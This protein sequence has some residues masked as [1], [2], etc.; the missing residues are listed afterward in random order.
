GKAVLD[1]ARAA[2]RLSGTGL[3]NA[4]PVGVMGYSQG[5]TSAGWAAQLAP[6]YAPD[7]KLKGVVAGG[8]PADLSAVANFLDG[9]LAFAFALM[10]AV[11]YDAAY[12]GLNLDGYLNA[13]GKALLANMQ[14]ICLVSVDGISGLVTTAFHHVS[15]YTTTNPLNTPQW[16]A[17]LNENKL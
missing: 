16:Q 11:G 8:V 13:D 5:G 4:N 14:N 6:T 10:A 7:L 17:K 12:P 2:E 9:G 15:D 1:A 3:S